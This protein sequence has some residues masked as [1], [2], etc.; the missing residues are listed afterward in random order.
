MFSRLFKGCTVIAFAGTDEKVNWLKNE[1][2]YDH[3]FNYKKVDFSE[4]I[5]RVAP[6]GVELFFDNVSPQLH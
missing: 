3:V 4:E 1:L 2:G 6:E 5:K